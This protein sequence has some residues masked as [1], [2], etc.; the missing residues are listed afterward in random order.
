MFSIHLSGVHRSWV[1]LCTL[2][3]CFINI[4]FS[5]YIVAVVLWFACDSI[6]CHRHKSFLLNF[7]VT[8]LKLSVLS[9]HIA[10]FVLH[11][12]L[13]AVCC[14]VNVLTVAY[15][16]FL[17]LDSHI[18]THLCVLMDSFSLVIMYENDCFSIC[19]E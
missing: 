16:T 19:D 7:L 2:S 6:P 12:M 14:F 4:F 13:P 5:F 3:H 15:R 8:V 1:D 17:S 11:T 10:S 18:P 9:S